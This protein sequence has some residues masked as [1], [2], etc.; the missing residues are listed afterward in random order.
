L[1]DEAGGARG[2][3]VFCGTDESQDVATRVLEFSIQKHASG[4]VE[5]FGMRDVALPVPKEEKNR[6]R[7]PFSFQRFCIPK[8]AGFR[9]RALYLDAD[10]QVFGDLAEL[11]RIPFGEQKVLCTTQSEAPAHW[12]G[13]S[14]FTPGR[15]FSVMLLDCAR[16]DWDIETIVRR[17]D[18]G[19]FDYKQLLH[20][21]CLVKP[22]E[23]ADRVPSE[24]NH[25]DHYVSPAE[26]SERS[27][28][29]TKLVHYTV[30]STQPWK[31]DR[32]QLVP[33]WMRCFAEAVQAGAVERDLVERGIAQGHLKPRMLRAFD[34]A[35]SGELEDSPFAK[36]MV[37][38][39]QALKGSGRTRWA[40][41]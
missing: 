36:A 30:V 16:L 22:D 5:F 18:A 13:H 27:V 4:P 12:K 19:E 21:C 31:N 41:P 6:Q 11:W 29:A 34:R 37:R 35:K 20:D 40:T 39:R 14:F 32:H 28:A 17:M 38:V 7:T 10:M 26:A 15:Q 23:I 24:W 2:M 9:G 3:R 1:N 25:L 8:L 33:L